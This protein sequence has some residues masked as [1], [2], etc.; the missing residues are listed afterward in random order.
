MAI[1]IR[2]IVTEHT[3]RV[4]ESSAGVAVVIST[5]D[6]PRVV[7]EPPS[8]FFFVLYR[9]MMD[10]VTRAPARTSA[11]YLRVSTYAAFSNN[12]VSTFSAGPRISVR[13]SL[14]WGEFHNPIRG[15]VGHTV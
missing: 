9:L 4:P 14:R 7:M 1:T 13:S 2:I 8:T 6:Q 3:T 11:T 12:S 5:A 15:T 10:A